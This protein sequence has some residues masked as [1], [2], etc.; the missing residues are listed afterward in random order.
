MVE[1][2]EE[3]EKQHGRDLR[4]LADHIKHANDAPNMM[5]QAYYAK[6]ALVLIP[7]IMEHQEA[8]FDYLFDALQKID[9]AR[10]GRE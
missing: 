1:I 10:G 3:T 4:Q 6:K 2:N 8:R 9:N 5:Q 7:R